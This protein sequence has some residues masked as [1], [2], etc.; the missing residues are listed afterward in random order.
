MLG[1][2]AADFASLEDSLAGRSEYDIDARKLVRIDASSAKQLLE[3]LTRLHAAGKKL[4]ILGL[5]TLVA[6]YL[7]T[8]GFADVAELRVRVI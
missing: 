1:A 6:A 2:S 7:E 3:V 8:L 5:S 4:R